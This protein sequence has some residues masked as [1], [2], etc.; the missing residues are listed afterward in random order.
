[1]NM[2][3]TI[4]TIMSILAVAVL[5]ISFSGCL[6]NSTEPFIEE[7]PV[8]DPAVIYDVTIYTLGDNV[9]ASIVVQIQ[10]TRSQ[11][12]DK[13]NITVNTTGN[14]VSVI[15]PVINS[16]DAN[17]RDFG[18]E[19][20]NILIGKK[21][22][23]KTGDYQLIINGDTPKTFIYVFKFT[24]GDLYI[25]KPAVIENAVIEVIDGKIIVNTTVVRGGSAETLDKA[26]ITVDG[27][28]QNND[29]AITIPVQ[30]KDGIT[31]L[32]IGWESITTEIGQLSDLADG[33][34][35]VTVNGTVVTFTVS[36]NQIVA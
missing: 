2:K 25:Y 21:S 11:S 1:M 3:K 17:T 28:L 5:A 36:G 32:I 20:V 23:F 31:T 33:D 27:T 18:Y 22:Q 12:L 4:L 30:I 10:G 24:G 7:R 35:T 14:N 19:T 8:Y 26:S 13:D 15:V 6:S 29:V 34:Y 16:G 9:M